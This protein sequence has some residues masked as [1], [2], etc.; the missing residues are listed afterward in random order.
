[1]ERTPS[2]RTEWADTDSDGTGNNAD[3]DDDNDGTPD[4][5]DAFPLDSNEDTD[6]DGDGI[7]NNAD[8]DDDG[9]G[10]G[11]VSDDADHDGVWNPNDTVITLCIIYMYFLIAFV[12]I[13]KI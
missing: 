8:L 6:T 2:H 4:G 3:T 5:E 12:T 9:D 7:G 10:V 11:D 1:M 13:L